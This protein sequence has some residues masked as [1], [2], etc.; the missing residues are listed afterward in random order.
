M[1]V[2]VCMCRDIHLTL[3]NL[4][5]LASTST[6]YEKMVFMLEIL[7]RSYSLLTRHFQHGAILN[8]LRFLGTKILSKVYLFI[9]YHPR[10]TT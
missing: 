7:A 4:S 3:T 8:I 9:I 10:P 6:F 1:H 2:F 5:F